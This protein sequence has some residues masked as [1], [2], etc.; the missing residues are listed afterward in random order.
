[1]PRFH[2]SLGSKAFGKDANPRL[3]VA[4]ES[5]QEAMRF[6]SASLA[7]PNG[8]ALLQGPAGSGKSTI[9]RE[10]AAWLERDAKVAIVEGAHLA[11][12]ELLT[13]MLNQFGIDADTDQEDL[14]LQIVNDFASRQ[15]M[16]DASPVL[17][18]DD[19]DRAMPSALRLVNWLAALEVRDRYSLRIVLTGKD[20]LSKLA[21]NDSLRRLAHRHPL[22]Y[23]LNPLTLRET[24]IY[25]HT[26][27]IA[28]GGNRCDRVF[29][30]EV[31]DQLRESSRGWPG[32]L[33]ECAVEVMDR[34]QGGQEVQQRPRVIVSRDGE[35]IADYELEKKTQYII[36]RTGLAD[37]VI[38]DGYV[39]KLH[40]LLK[41]YNNAVALL[42]LNS[43]NGT[44][45]N[46]REVEKTILRNNDVVA[47][48]R[49]RLK[50]ENLPAI[51]EEVAERIK[52]A[53]TQVLRSLEDIRRNRAR[54]T[55]AALK[56]R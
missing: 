33:N 41:V 28:A 49:H 54:R 43:T 5:H 24:Q 3:I 17:I 36:G 6:L 21:Q 18:I 11:P 32:S 22:V 30:I 29:P 50:I 12:R 52:A 35:V 9:V 20:R 10:Q 47:L 23:S 42:D 37:I 34:M 7:Q 19:A 48:G 2:S 53:D 1:M 27:L 15:A 38:E 14:L 4:Y 40:A 44:T 39:S 16:Q 31:C 13:G 45:V 46:S 55:V 25:L 8:I 51:S 26:R 56:H